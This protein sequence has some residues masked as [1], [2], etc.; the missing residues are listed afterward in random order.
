MAKGEDLT[1]RYKDYAVYLPSLQQQYAAYPLRSSATVRD[2]E[3]PSKMQMKDLNF[4]DPKSSF[5]HCKY[6]LYSAGQFDQAH[7]S[8]PDIV[9]TRDQANTVVIGDSGGF[10]IGT[11]KLPAVA[12][13]AKDAKDPNVIYH[14]W[15]NQR[16]IRDRVLRWLDRYS[17]Y[18]MTLDM[19]LWI[20]NE[21]KAQKSSPFAKLSAQQLIDLS[22]ENL[23]YF[24]DNRGKATGSKAKYLNVLQ[25]AGNGTGEAWYNAV[26]D[27]DFEGW[28]FGGDTKNGIEPVLKWMRRLLDDGKLDKCEWVHI[29]MASPPESAVYFTAIQRAL[30]KAT[31]NEKLQI[32]FDSSSP[33]QLSG[34]YQKIA[35]LPELTADIKSW[36]IQ[37]VDYPQSPTY[38]SDTDIRYLQDIQS[39]ITRAISINDF[40][41]K[42]TGWEVK[43]F[44]T[45]SQQLL[46]N[47]NMYIYH[48]AAI[49]ACNLV[50]DV[51][52]RGDNRIPIIVS[53]NLKK[54]AT[55]F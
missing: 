45:F 18:A 47:H 33:F 17:D 1:A 48:R 14:R 16:S 6:V 42:R 28:A 34:I 13:W 52:N 39:P 5:W 54:I 25:D 43:F 50:F 11:G 7:I 4:L 9:S 10:Q 27:F 44:D 51:E 15:L 3:L 36:R 24:A 49:E 40:H 30:R 26:K 12:H 55:C 35:K 31:G 21:K 19:P 29:L 23:R 46:T 37:S 32:S 38:A 8:K 20:L 2:G 22:V 41:A 53:N